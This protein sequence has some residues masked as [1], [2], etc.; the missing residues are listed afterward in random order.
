MAVKKRVGGVDYYGWI[1]MGP[2]IPWGYN[3]EITQ[4]AFEREFQIF[5]KPPLPPSPGMELYPNPTND[6]LHFG[7]FEFENIKVFSQQ[8]SLI[9]NQNVLSGASEFTIDVHSW[10]RGVYMVRM[11]SEGNVVIKEFVKY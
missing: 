5:K 4:I 3:F 10:D 11:E 8:G 1:K 6:I 7:Q 9:F 2:G